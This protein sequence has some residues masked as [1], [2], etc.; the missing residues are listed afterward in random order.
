MWVSYRLASG[1]GGEG[2]TLEREEAV[3]V[4][5]LPLPIIDKE[6]L[7]PRKLE[8]GR[9]YRF[10][11]ARRVQGLSFFYRWALAEPH[12]RELPPPW[13]DLVGDTVVEAG[14]PQ[15]IEVAL[16]LDDP[17]AASASFQATFTDVV[18]FRSGTS[19]VPRYLTEGRGD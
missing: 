8:L 15:G 16:A 17:G 2:T 4:G 9:S 7:R 13:A 5:P 10:R 14:V 1:R 3:V 19:P 12:P 18:T 11:L 6:S